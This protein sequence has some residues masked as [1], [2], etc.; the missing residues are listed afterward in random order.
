MAF[1]AGR[2]EFLAVGRL[3]RS[4]TRPRLALAHWAPGVRLCTRCSHPCHV[5]LA[6]VGSQTLSVLDKKGRRAAPFKLPVLKPGMS[7]AFRQAYEAKVPNPMDLG[8]VVKK[9]KAGMYANGQ[10][11]IDDVHLT[12]DNAMTFNPPTSEYHVCVCAWRAL[13]PVCSCRGLLTPHTRRAS[14]THPWRPHATAQ[15]GQGA[16][17]A[18]RLDAA[19]QVAGHP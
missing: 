4:H 14:P 12:F 9:A 19:G 2:D 6:C 13:L 5:P 11:F 10:Q 15:L 17:R 8:T 3:R 16:E 1:D 7:P 18:V